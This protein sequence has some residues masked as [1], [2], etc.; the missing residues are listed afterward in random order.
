VSTR[1]NEEQLTAF[2]DDALA[3]IAEGMLA[4]ARTLQHNAGVA[5]FELARR[6]K[7][8]GATHVETEH[9]SGRLVPGGFV[10]TVADPEALCEALREAGV[11]GRDVI[12]AVYYSAPPPPMLVVNHRALN[13]LVKLGGAISEAINAHRQSERGE[14]KLELHRKQEIEVEE[15]K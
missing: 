13:E 11:V 15:T 12:G 9:W 14:P 6:L 7:E 5:R 3:E 1:L 2:T 8:R 10:H 4:E